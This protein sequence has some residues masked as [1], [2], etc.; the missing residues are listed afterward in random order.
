MQLEVC[1]GGGELLPISLLLQL[2]NQAPIIQTPPRFIKESDQS[3]PPPLPCRK[4]T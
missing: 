4:G 1:E 3:L 2:G